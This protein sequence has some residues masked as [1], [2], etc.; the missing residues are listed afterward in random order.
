VAEVEKEIL[1]RLA[2]AE[3]LD[4]I[5]Q[6]LADDVLGKERERYEDPLPEGYLNAFQAI[7]SDPNNE[8]TVACR[9]TE[10]I[11]VMQITFTP[12][13][14]HQGSWRATI[15]GVR[16]SSAVRGQGVGSKMINW[17]V[18]R[19]RERGC[20]LVQLTTDK[21]RSDALRFYQKLG[22]KATHEGLKMKL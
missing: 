17:A 19:A 22:F 11:G 15:E 1:F 10:I 12:Y 7:E 16:T 14:T 21:Q 20:S 5:V 13:L 4:R 3:D 9:G 18:G 2:A 6:M 8:L